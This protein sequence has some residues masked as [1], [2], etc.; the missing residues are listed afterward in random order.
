MG[1]A[2]STA[3][4]ATLTK[5]EISSFM[6]PERVDSRDR[7]TLAV[8]R[9][10]VETY[11][12]KEAGLPLVMDWYASNPT[13]D[14]PERVAGGARFEQDA[15]GQMALVL[16]SEDL[17]QSILECVTPRATPQDQSSNDNAMEGK[18]LEEEEFREG[19]MESREAEEMPSQ[20]GDDEGDLEF[21][22]SELSIPDEESF[23]PAPSINDAAL[24]PASDTWRNVP[25]EDA[26]IKFAV[27]GPR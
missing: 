9:A 16:E 21:E 19:D 1:L 22:G 11:A 20:S 5:F 6:E 7:T 27:G 15:N 8:H 2:K 3:S 13:D 17:R 18:E 23:D 26:A 25:L 14:Y 10:L 12:L 4:I 24:M